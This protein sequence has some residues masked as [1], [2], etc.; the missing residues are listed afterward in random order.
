MQDKR[1]KPAALMT[2]GYEGASIEDFV[3]T[4]Q[5][6]AIEVLLDIRDVPVS[7]KF[8]F[9]KSLLAQKLNDVEIEYIHIR[10]LGNPKPGREAARKGDIE[11]F[12]RIFRN[13]LANS[14]SQEALNKAIEI[15]IQN[16]VVLLCFER[17]HS[18]CHR[19]IVAE[20][21][22][23]RKQFTVDHI[24]VIPDLST[25]AK[26]SQNVVESAHAFG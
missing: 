13:H 23:K 4:L 22:S 9:S 12:E 21:M 11:E 24:N 25:K 19:S 18:Y 26:R 3:A 1:R 20:A 8:G 2:I 17:D 6:A 10:E 7:R 15:A 5:D 16:L 14:D